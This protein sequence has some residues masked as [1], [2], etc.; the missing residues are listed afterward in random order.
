[1]RAQTGGRVNAAACGL[2]WIEV[3]DV[4]LLSLSLELLPSEG[5]CLLHLELHLTE[6]K[7]RRTW[8]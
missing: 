4:G 5:V 2:T 6:E 3:L 7:E 8:S 1:M